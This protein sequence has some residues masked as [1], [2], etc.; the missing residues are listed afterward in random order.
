MQH[1][2]IRLASYN[3][4]KA[5]GLDQKRK[6]GRTLDVINAL[7]A[8]VVVLQEADKRLGQRPTAVPRKM[9]EAETDFDLVEVARNGVS[10]GWHG[11]AVLVR[12][13]IGVRSIDPLD[14]PGLEPRG[15]VRLTLDVGA[16]LTVV[17]A[18][19]GLRR[20][21]RLAQLDA[22]NTAT[23]ADAHCVI[24][25]D[26]NEWSDTK[27]F[28]P[29]AARFETHTPGRSFHARRPI[30]ALDRFALSRDVALHN[31]GVD[32]S[33]LARVASDHLPIW[34]DIS[35]PAATC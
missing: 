23:S 19:L 6:P 30:A 13:G 8:D 27:G 9:I 4:R 15:A 17:A 3:I 34:S 20:R 14:L 33:A 25:G 24:A 35:V 32:Q 10:I 11:N 22:L 31:A 16:G 26:F 28:E 7:G 18:H 29:L 2:R 1:S 5:R 12:R 21:D